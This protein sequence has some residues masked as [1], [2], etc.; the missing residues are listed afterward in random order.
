MKTEYTLELNENRLWL[1][2]IL[3]ALG[4][5]IL[6]VMHVTKSSGSLNDNQI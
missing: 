6:N 4:A 3:L 2:A 1:S 5:G